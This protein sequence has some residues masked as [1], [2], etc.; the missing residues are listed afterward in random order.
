MKA[1][2]IA[3]ALTQLFF[4]H[5]CAACGTDA[6]D[7]KQ[8]L[9]FSCSSNLPITNFNHH[10]D[11][12]VEKVFWGRIPLFGAASYM[13]F[14]KQS[15]VQ[16]LMHQFKYKGH[17]EI[18]FYFGRKLGESIVDSRRFM[19]LDGLIPL[20]LHPRKE[21]KRGYNQ[22]MVLCEG[23]AEILKVP[24]FSGAV[25][26]A[27]TTDTQTRKSRLERWQ[28]MEGRFRVREPD[29]LVNKMVLLVDDIITTGATLESCGRELLAVPG[30]A[31][32]VATL[33]Y[34]AV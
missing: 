8:L 29:T 21:K 32:G 14:S 24:V 22:A 6:L 1:N 26:R 23:M 25:E 28:N 18:G 10:T 30:L 31:L 3:S 5:V 4:P 20:P 13:Y 2:V 9:C 16:K 34:T 27:L 17:K 15:S 19:E 12:P 33:A 7:S 11:N